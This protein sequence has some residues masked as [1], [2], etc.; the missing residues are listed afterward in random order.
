MTR[1][2]GAG[3][4]PT[5]WGMERIE[6]CNSLWLL[7]PALMQFCRVPKGSDPANAVSAHWQAYFAL[8]HEP[9]T[10][11]FRVALDEARTRWLTSWRHTDLCPR[12]AE[13]PTRE[14]VLAP[15]LSVPAGDRSELP[16]G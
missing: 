16:S 12:C 2:G 1:C 4:A 6:T 7:D 15:T 10:G 8:E 3:V 9:D 13:E 11:A 14:V 5:V